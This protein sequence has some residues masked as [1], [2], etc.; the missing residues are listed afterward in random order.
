MNDLQNIIPRI[1]G[2]ALTRAL[3]EHPVV[4]LQGARQTG[5]TTLA[6]MP[7]IGHN[8]SYVTLDDFDTMET[9]SRDPAALFIGRQQITLDEVQRRPEILLAIK[10]DVDRNRQAGRF[11]LTGSANL[12]LMK[13]VSET[14][15]GRA[16]Y[17]LLPPFIW[18]EI[19]GREF[20]NLL[21]RLLNQSSVEEI[22]K[23][24][25]T[26]LPR[27]TRKLSSAVFAGGYPVPAL[28][29]DIA[30][31]SSWF[32]G[33]VQTYLERDLRDFSA[34]DN[35]VEFRRLMRICAAQNGRVLNIASL[36]NDAGL[37]PATARR[38]LNILEASFQ[39]VTIPAYAVNKGKR[40]T[41]APKIFWNDTGL[42]AHLAGM[43][44]QNSLRK[45]REWGAWL[46]NWLA[47][48]IIV[49]TS[50]HI[51]RLQLFH[52]RTSSGHEVDFVI[53]FGQRLLPIEVKATTKPA[54][55]DI[56]GLETFMDT[57]KNAPLGIIVCQCE[58]PTV[59]S[60]RILALPFESL[61]LS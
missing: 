57:Y 26:T 58:R 12:L 45:S 53:E 60:T 11:L 59:I 40:L 51:P 20:G 35:L 50:L 37:S 3:Q 7:A 16:V 31:R 38:Y 47:N 6:R 30:F 13:R 52:W 2:A 23:N 46:E 18:S 33:Y 1:Q 39:L 41:K 61:L 10:A 5:K 4:I 44:D 21:E 22:L 36:A 29:E 14:L 19:E 8:R 24:M 55:K 17:C 43:F 49:Y 34:T 15:A 42:A 56:R 48:H 9:A 27:P 54:R 32:D 25:A 28:S